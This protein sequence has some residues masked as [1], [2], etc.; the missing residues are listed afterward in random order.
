MGLEPWTEA[1]QVTPPR[2]HAEHTPRS[3]ALCRPSGP[4]HPAQGRASEYPRGSPLVQA[5]AAACL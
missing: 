3:D 4:L 2:S 5:L 1:A